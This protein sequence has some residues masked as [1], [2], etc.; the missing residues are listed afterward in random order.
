MS[1]NRYTENLYGEERRLIQQAEREKRLVFFV[2]AGVSIPSGMPSWATSIK[3]IKKRMK[4]I[5]QDD[6]LKI[7]QYYYVQH[8]KRDYNRL[9]WAVFKYQ[10]TL[11]TNHIHRELFKFQVKTIVTT[12]YDHLLEEAAKEN[13][14]VFDVIGQDSDLAY[15][16]AENKIIKMHGD[17]EHDNFVL[18]EDDYL[19]YERNFRLLTAY[20]KALIAE[21]TMIFIG[22]SF[23]DPD[24]KQIFSWVK[25]VLGRDMPRSYMIVTK[26]AYSEAEANYFKNFGITVLY[27]KMMCE[28]PEHEEQLVQMLQFLREK[29]EQTM[30]EKIYDT[31]KPLQDLNY[32]HGRYIG[33]PFLAT[34]ICL[35]NNRLVV[36]E[37]IGFRILNWLSAFGGNVEIPYEE[38]V[39]DEDKEYYREIYGILA[40]SSV[41]WHVRDEKRKIITVTPRMGKNT[42]MDKIL[43]AIVE[44]DILELKKMR[45]RND[46]MLA[47]NPVLY[48]E[49]AGLSYYLGEYV[50]AYRYLQ[51]GTNIFYQQRKYVWYF[52]S[53]LNR[54]YLA[55]I[56]SRKSFS[57]YSEKEQNEI[58][59]DADA[60]D[61]DKIFYSLPDIGNEDNTFLRELYTFQVFYSSLLPVQKK[62]EEA[63]K[64]SRTSYSLFAKIPAITELRQY[65]IENW[66]YLVQ[67][68]ILLDQYIE[69]SSGIRQYVSSLLTAMTA[70]QIVGREE[71]SFVDAVGNIQPEELDAMDIYFILR[72]LPLEDMKFIFSQSEEDVQISISDDGVNRL[73]HILSNLPDIDV[74]ERNELFEKILCLSCHSARLP[75]LL[76]AVLQAL[77]N[78]VGNIAHRQVRMAITDFFASALQCE[79]LVDDENNAE[80]LLH[81]FIEQLL[82]VIA[83]KNIAIDEIEC[84]LERALYLQKKLNNVGAF[85]SG[86]V[87]DLMAQEDLDV[88][89]ILYPY[90]DD[91]TKTSISALAQREEWDFTMLPDRPTMNARDLDL[92][93][94]TASER[95]ADIYRRDRLGLFCRLLSAKILQPNKEVEEQLLAVLPKVRDDREDTSPSSYDYI[96]SCITN[97]YLADAFIEKER[98]RECIRKTN[99]AELIWVVDWERYDYSHFQC[100]WLAYCSEKLLQTMGGNEKVRGWIQ[101]AVQE[102]YLNGKIKKNIF[103]IYFNYFVG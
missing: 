83:E 8:G 34:G 59:Q 67:N 26:T 76:L 29:E 44:Y 23:N 11:P 80:Q 74:V 86:Y 94:L 40:K 36:I 66:N 79:D 64:E 24:L 14:R 46:S 89:R 18:K 49:Q 93:D 70:L 21:N 35:D 50:E 32:V 81:E 42:N 43:S 17:F 100:E 5:L 28:A 2:G 78:H 69:F 48:V 7:S 82:C 98:I 60:I 20:I 101:K 99:I 57:Q 71:S 52:I 73:S 45:Q 58:W 51:K 55:R 95:L 87:S 85:K 62:A 54:K 68:F 92:S 6:A 88:L 10:K 37:N 9:M 41:Y 102:Q 16:F 56:I 1:T 96:F 33:Q 30:A 38:D 27:A 15:G 3:Q 22:Y 39:S 84:L 103:K 75:A 65:V 47:A 90:V 77:V 72:Y 97:A 63:L 61:L 25:D 13:Y 91:D 4:G 12:N 31:L 53:L 19:H